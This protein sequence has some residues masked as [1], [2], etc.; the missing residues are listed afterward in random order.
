[1]TCQITV[2]KLEGYGAW[3]LSLGS[4][5]EY[6]LQILQSKMYAGI[7]EYFSIKNGL[8]FSNRFDEFIAITNQISLQEHKEIYDKISQKDERINISM[9]LGVGDT[10]LKADKRINSIKKDSRNS[11]F[12]NIYGIKEIEIGQGNHRPHGWK[13]DHSE[14]DVKIL[15]IDVDSS[16][17]ISEHL[18]TYEITNLVV[19]L[20][21]TISNSFLKEDS[22][23]FFLGGDNF[24]VIARNNIDIKRITE[25]ID[26][27]TNSTGIK[28]NC[29]VGNG[30]NARMAAAKATKS[31]DTIRDYRRNGKIINVYE[32]S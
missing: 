15:H 7:Q 16:K 21:S 20:Y 23:T 28:L 10:P 6:I 29:G 5:R 24:M 12:P 31:L 25:I 22:L 9:T 8:V 3:T 2:I 13:N 14:H 32:S 4:D 11:I 27:L 18:S 17:S 1:M 30:N 26:L 19:N